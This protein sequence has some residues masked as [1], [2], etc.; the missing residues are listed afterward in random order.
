MILWPSLLAVAILLGLYSAQAG[1]AAWEVEATRT[2]QSWS[3]A[4]MRHV[5]EFMTAIGHSPWYLATAVVGATVL[6]GLRHAWLAAGLLA[7]SLLRTTSPLLKDLVGRDRPSPALVDVADRLASPSFPSGHVLG[8]TLIY[9]FLIYAVEVAVPVY[10]LKRTIQGG[11]AAMILL[12]GYAR[13]E[14]GEHWPIDVLGGWIIGALMIAGLVWMHRR[15]DG[16][17]TQVAAT[18]D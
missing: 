6:L 18:I 3:P 10:W 2:L 11:L 14:L 12:M 9:G 7:A 1:Q 16:Q 8:A 5:A 15:V 4:P 17:R 13:V